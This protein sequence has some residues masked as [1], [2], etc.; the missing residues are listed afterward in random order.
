MAHYNTFIPRLLILQVLL[1]RWRCCAAVLGERD[2]ANDGLALAWLVSLLR[3]FG[4]LLLKSPPSLL[5]TPSC[6]YKQ[7]HH[8]WV[9]TPNTHSSPAFLKCLTSRK[10]RLILTIWSHWWYF[11]SVQFNLMAVAVLLVSNLFTQSSIGCK[12]LF[13]GNLKIFGS[14]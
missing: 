3:L 5:V 2:T 9:R 13:D 7:Q 1:A 4:S 11:S 8:Q 10:Q 12:N 6:C 14:M